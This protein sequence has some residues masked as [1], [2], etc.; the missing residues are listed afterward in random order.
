MKKLLLLIVLTISQFVFAQS[1]KHLE[2]MTTDSIKTQVTIKGTFEPTANYTWVIMYRITG[3]QQ[4]YV[5]NTG[6]K[7]GKFSMKMPKNA[8]QGMYRLTYDINNNG[9]IDFIY[10]NKNIELVFNPRKPNNS[11]KFIHSEENKYFQS[12]LMDSRKL[13]NKLDALQ[14]SYFKTKN[15]KKIAKDYRSVYKNIEKKQEKYADTSRA[16]ISESFIYALQKYNT[17]EIIETGQEYL[18]STKAHFFDFIDFKNPLLMNSTIITKKVVNYIYYLNT[19]SDYQMQQA[20]YKR[21]LLDVF[22]KTEDQP[23][24]EAELLTTLMYGFVQMKNLPMV[25]FIMDTY[26]KKLPLNIQDPEVIKS[27]TLQTKVAVGRI[28]PDFSYDDGK[29]LNQFYSIKNQEPI[30]LVFWST[31]CSHC[32]KEIPLLHAY[33]KLHKN[34]KIVAV[35]LEKDEL[36]FNH[37]KEELANFTNILA[38]DKW[39]NPIAKLYNINSTPNYFIVDTHKK[40][41]AKPKDVKEL[42]AF[43]NTLENKATDTIPLKENK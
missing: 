12:Y 41:I 10:N 4:R 43:F 16:T 20:L 36:G 23:K 9:Y 14:I 31:S 34:I 22:E 42:K 27:I 7:K 19:S 3:S 26:Y 5:A 15:K 8:I 21:S 29:K 28:A 11:V 30:V 35:A 25:D 24:L 40:I 38:L 17:P 2:L 13:Q 6:L 33:S 39:K 32:L 18:N 37:Y 1:S